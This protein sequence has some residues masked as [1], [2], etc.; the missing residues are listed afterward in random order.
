MKIMQKSTR[1][2]LAV[3]S[4]VLCAAFVTGCTVKAKTARHQQRADNYFAEGNY[5]KAEV[6]YL[7]T[8][9]L[10]NENKRATSQLGEIYFQQG[11]YSRAFAFVQKACQ[12]STNDVNMQLKLATI[13]LM[14]QKN[15]EAR[16]A[17]QYVLSLSPTN[18]EAPDIIAE[19]AVTRPEMVTARKWLEEHSKKTG[20][21]AAM[22]LAFGVLDY[23]SGDVKTAETEVQRSLTLD[24]KFSAAH[25]TMGNLYLRKG[26]VKEAD[27][28]FKL[29]ADL[30]P[31]RSVRRLSYANFKI[32]SG[33]VAEGKRLLEEITKEAPDYVPAWIRQA[34]VA[35]AEKRYDDCEALLTKALTHDSDNFDALFIRGRMYL[36][37]GKIDKAVAEFSRMAALYDHSPEVQYQLAMAE[38]A[39]KDIPKAIT[40]LN[41]A[42]FLRPKY[43]DAT[44]LLAGLNVSKGDIDS[45]VNSLTLLLKDWPNYGQAHL[46]LGE[47]YL[48]QN[49]LDSAYQSF[50]KAEALLPNNPQ[51]PFLRG[52]ILEQKKN[53]AEARKAF[54]HALQISPTL[55][56]ALEE[57][58]NLDISEDKYTAALDRVNKET[59]EK[60][61]SACQVL[62]AKI[63]MARAQS[64]AAKQ[65]P[66]ASG[67]VKLDSP[68][69]QSDVNLAESALLKA[70]ELSPDQPGNYMLL[71]RLY[72]SAGKQQA[73]LD[74]LNGL[75]A[76]KKNA[77]AYMQI[78]MIYDSLKDY[79][80]ARDAYEN[81]IAA[82][83]NFTPAI[84]NLSYLYSERLNDP[85]KAYP[86][87][88]KA[89]DLDPS[90]PSAAD[91][92]G[93]ITYK[94][95]DYA[96]ARPM[97]E[98]SAAKL[99]TEPEVSY[100]L[101]MV[102]YMMGDEEPARQALQKA[103]AATAEFPG[104]A[105]ALKRLATLA[106]DV[107]TANERTQSD[108]EQRL[109]DEPNDPVAA[110]RLGGI[111]E[112]N[113]AYDKAAKTYE[114]LLKLNPQDGPI[115]GRLARV[116]MR[117]NQADKALDMA[118]DAHKALPADIEISALL[119]R[120]VFLSG[121]YNWSLNLLED[122]AGKLP[123]QA[124][125]R[126][127]LAWA[128]YSLGRVDDAQRTMQSAAPALTGSQ[129]DDAKQFL[130]LVAA[131]K[132]PAQAASLPANQILNTNA[133]YV[134]AMMVAG[135]QAEKQSKPEDAAKLYS[136][137]LAKYPAFAPA[138][139][140]LVI[141][142][143]KNA[144]L[145]DD[146]KSFDL[147][148]KVR[149]GNPDDTDLTRA[150]GVL[151]YRRGD[152]SRA[153]SLLQDSSQKLTN[154]GE[155]YYFLGM[156]QYQL[157]RPTAKPSL[158]RALALNVS[159]KYADDAKKVLQELSKN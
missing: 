33:D 45:A 26:M 130:S 102:R 70:I 142:E 63:Y 154:D 129:S 157:K 54:E 99:T 60:L 5:S 77:P 4:A 143:S 139:R 25:Y 136:K 72:I 64:V 24:P 146:Q 110:A 19:S 120:L 118:K 49:N 135:V 31:K 95:G 75:V 15:A 76:K 112:R 9:R 18:M 53:P 90:D 80:K 132:D 65:N 71:G 156:S 108:L 121:D 87:A 100:H 159:S 46:L 16:S 148:V 50:A 35:L 105:E 145:P 66:N 20:E 48:G 78:G 106:I 119:G 32:E 44:M 107:K 81:A 58:V 6:E 11:R 51:V 55:V 14:V 61:A 128:Y 13:Y 67:P 40:A 123:N 96:H 89:F 141:L 38:A 152:Y 104:K 150:L 59:N 101:G 85:D 140:S 133:D 17:A 117:L 36:V 122:A 124:E 149:A 74:R 30:S 126:Y 12:L 91:T 10:D 57:L 42:L 21:T 158:Q 79:P 1:V 86:L 83:P 69:V 27:A 147:A 82:N 56:R 22:Q 23:A 88:K 113:G 37:T 28:E 84:N 93:W 153:A 109:K 73:A 138:A 52:M 151:A 39:S 131:G 103:A 7:V 68:A 62:L 114:Q 116:Y 115:M 34:E 29:A 144:S 41:K 47:A 111:Y 137:A 97:I 92:L 134:P 3:L 98:E 94:K 125:V 2:F 8:L 155:V 43:P 127:N